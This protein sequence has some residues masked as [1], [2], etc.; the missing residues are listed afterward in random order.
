M[1][2]KKGMARSPFVYVEVDGVV[3]TLA[4][5]SRVFN[6]PYDRLQQRYKLGLRGDALFAKRYQTRKVP[7]SL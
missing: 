3:G 5:W 2:N 7:R 1:Q 6:I 4:H